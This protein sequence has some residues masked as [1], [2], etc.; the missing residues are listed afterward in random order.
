MKAR[1]GTD[2]LAAAMAKSVA[3][4]VVDGRMMGGMFM[5]KSIL[6]GRGDG[7][8]GDGCLKA[9]DRPRTP[10]KSSVCTSSVPAPLRPSQSVRC[11]RTSTSRRGFLWFRT[12]EDEDCLRLY[13]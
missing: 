5:V 6:C 13:C 7:M 4:A 8:M 11:P 2:R 1:S 3:A 12:V 10:N 9:R